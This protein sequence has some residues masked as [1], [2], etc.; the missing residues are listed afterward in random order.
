[1]KKFR[2]RNGSWFFRGHKAAEKENHE[3][4]SVLLLY[5]PTLGKIHAW[6]IWLWAKKRRLQAEGWKCSRLITFLMNDTEEKIIGR[7]H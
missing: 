1:M 6:K 7:N 4:N 2:A 5:N 3:S